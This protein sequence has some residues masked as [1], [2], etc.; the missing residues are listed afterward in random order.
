[1]LDALKNIKDE[2]LN[3]VINDTE[4]SNIQTRLTF[5]NGFEDLES[6][7][8]EDRP[9]ITVTKKII[10][11]STGVEKIFTKSLSQLSLGQQQ[12]ILLA[13]LLQSKSKYP[14]IIDQ[15]EDNLDSEFI[16]KTIVSNL[17]RIK[18]NRQVI[19]ITHNPNIAV[20]GDAELIIPLKSTSIKSIITE[21]GSIDKYET[22]RL[23]CDILEGGE[24]A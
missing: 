3:R 18:E 1:N 16:Y 2:E 6:I 24:Q 5:N 23:C 14:L 7:K 9:T 19:I 22:R 8:F 15:P 10:D 17:R 4:L 12:S 13:I 21:R 11:E 20:L